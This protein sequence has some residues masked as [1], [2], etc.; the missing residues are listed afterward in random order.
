MPSSFLKQYKSQIE[1]FIDQALEEDL[2]EGDHS[3]LSCIEAEEESSA[4]L[5][6]KEDGIL[7]GVALA[8]EIFTRFDPRL[9]IQ[10]FLK[11]G[12]KIKAGDIAFSVQGPT[13]S[14][15]STERLVLNSLQRM[16]G[17]ATLTQELTQQI[18]HTACKLLDTRKTTPNFRYPEK[19]AVRIG[20]GRNHR[21]GLFDAVMIKDNHIDFCGGMQAALEKTQKYLEDYGKSLEVVVECRDQVEI[22]AALPFPFVS[23]LLLDNYKPEELKEAVQFIGE[24]K[25]TEASGTITKTNLIAYAESGVDFISMGALTYGA[26]NIDLSLKAV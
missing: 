21:M 15:L 24:K 20:G 14:I 22:E 19:W 9:Q 26:K 17:I 2:G 3:S 5:L 6:V 13:R 23:R 4:Q 7:A 12:S 25:T 1:K 8:K 11:D 16:S 10:L 18:Q